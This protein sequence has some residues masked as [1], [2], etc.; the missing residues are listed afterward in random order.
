MTDLNSSDKITHDI[1]AH[2]LAMAY[3]P[4]AAEC[5]P[6]VVDGPSYG[7]SVH[8]RACT[9]LPGDWD[10]RVRLYKDGLLREQWT[11]AI[12][13]QA[14]KSQPAD[15]PSFGCPVHIIFGLQDVALDPRIVVDGINRYFQDPAALA[16][17]AHTAEE[18]IT[19]LPECGH[20]PILEEEG[21]KAL[22]T[23]LGRI[24]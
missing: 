24:L 20:W 10:G 23:T 8:A 11:M 17:P 5:V 15:S 22:D 3:G 13:D 16:N 19:R 14:V 1:Y 2:R 6:P 7:P 4:S 21:A 12:S 9:S 18:R